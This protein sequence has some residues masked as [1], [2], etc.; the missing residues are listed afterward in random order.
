MGL[1]DEKPV[2]LLSFMFTKRRVDALLTERN[3]GG[4]MQEVGEIFYI[5]PPAF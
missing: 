4:R 5:L 3:R 2:W 1:I